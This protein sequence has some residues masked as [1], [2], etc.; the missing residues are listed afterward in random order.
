MPR[1]VGTVLLAALLSATAPGCGPP[2]VGADRESFEAV[3]ALYT[4]VGLRD[5]RL[6]ADSERRLQALRDSGRLPE[7]AHR[8]LAGI[9]ATARAGEWEP[10][11]DRLNTFMSGQTR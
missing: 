8:A 4:A 1:T 11:I 10:S 2:Q 7:K 9:I 5:A 3:D 6:V